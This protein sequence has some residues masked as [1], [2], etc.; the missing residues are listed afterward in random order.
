MK[1]RLG[2]WRQRHWWLGLGACW[3]HSRTRRARRRVIAQ[4]TTTTPVSDTR[5]P[6]CGH[7]AGGGARATCATVKSLIAQGADVTFDAVTA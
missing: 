6:W 4:R 2:V 5:E 7:G 1:S 3:P